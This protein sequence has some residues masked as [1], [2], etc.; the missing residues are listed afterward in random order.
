MQT[1]ETT[2][3]PT[4]SQDHEVYR[5]LI[6]ATKALPP[7][8]T[9][10]AH[11]CD[12]PSLEG[13]LDAA[14]ADIIEPVLVG[15][16]AR[17]KAAAEALG[18]SIDGYELVDAEHSHASAERAVALI[19]E[20][21]GAFLMK[22]SLHSDE[23]LSAVTR[24]DTGLRTERRIS[25]VFAMAVPTY[26]QPLFIT[27]AAVNIFPD[28]DAKRDIVQNAIDRA[29]ALKLDPKV[30]I[31]SAV[32]TVTSKIPSTIEAAALCKMAVAAIHRRHCST[33]RS[34]LDNAISP[35]GT[36]QGIVSPVAARPTSGR[37]RPRGRQHAGQDLT[38]LAMPMRR[39]SFLGARVPIVLTSPRDTPRAR[40]AS[41]AVAA[42]FAEYR[43]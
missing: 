5:R 4:K 39:A 6:K 11:P 31:L 24:R 19:N 16:I 9:I 8:R 20:G 14:D 43:G 10:V 30:A 17:I 36:D 41:C 34:R 29:S 38:F 12:G 28:L 25:H 37:A 22:G 18:R 21:R 40:M 13:A 23:I 42:L 2:A 27:D 35:S 1:D 3:M 26:N 33:G 32:E 15:P 7:T